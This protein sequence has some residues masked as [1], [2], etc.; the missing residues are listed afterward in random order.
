MI[1]GVILDSSVINNASGWRV[2]HLAT[3]ID[4]L[5]RYNVQIIVVS[6]HPKGPETRAHAEIFKRADHRYTKQRIQGNKGAADWVTIPAHRIG[7]EPHELLYVGDDELDWRSA[8][9]GGCFF[10][11]AAWSKNIKPSVT[12]IVLREPEQI[13]WFASHYLLHPPRWQVRLDVP[14]DQLILRSLLEGNVVL[15]CDPP[16][17]TFSLKDVFTHHKNVQVGGR[18]A[19]N[20]LLMHALASARLEGLIPPRALV[21]LYPG[22]IPGKFNPE[23]ESYVEIASKA[24]GTLFKSDLLERTNAAPDTSL[25]RAKKQYRN[26][27]F[28]IQ[29]NS[30]CVNP[31]YSDSIVGKPVIV[32]DEFTTAGNSFEWARLLLLEAGAE[33]VTLISVGKFSNR[34]AVHRPEEDVWIQ[35]FGAGGGYRDEDFAV[36]PKIVIVNSAGAKIV[37]QSFAAMRDGEFY[38]LS[39]TSVNLPVEFPED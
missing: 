11:H 4:R 26:A 14:E 7:A 27:T 16:P 32:L 6:T 30:V 21:C 5:K 39:E 29:A 17:K 18:P 13:W 28:A 23:M 1:K 34:H 8:I 20:V 33:S 31:K 10:V 24:F 37:E 12:A 35:P 36:E 9:N 19:R 38:P 3:V 15:P 2:T 22:H 25:E